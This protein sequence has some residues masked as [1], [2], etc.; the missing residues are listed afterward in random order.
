MPSYIAENIFSFFNLS[1]VIAMAIYI[2]NNQ[3]KRIENVEMTCRVCPIHSI[4]AVIAEIRT[5]IKWIKE[6]LDKL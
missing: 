2:F 6:K 1:C 4:S 3:N 5:D